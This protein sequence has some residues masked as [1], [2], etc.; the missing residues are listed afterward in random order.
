[1]SKLTLNNVADL[2][3][4]TTAVSV[5]NNNNDL[6]ETAVE[7]TLSLDG[8]VPN[9]MQSSF[10]MNSNQIINLPQ[11]A[12]GNSPLR[13]QDLEDFIGGGT[14]TN[15]PAGGNTN[16]VLTKASNSDYD[17]DWSSAASEVVAGANISVTG[18]S[19]AT[20][21]T[22]QNPNF[23]TSVTTPVINKVTITAPATNATLTIPDGV[24][25]TGPAVSGTAMTLGNT[26]VVTGAKTF[27]AATLTSPVINGASS[28][29]GVATASTPSTLVLR[30]AAGSA[31]VNSAIS[32]YTTTAT[33]AGTTTLT[34]SSTYNQ[35]FTGVT[36]QTVV[37]PVTSTLVLGQSYRIVNNSTGAVT[38]QSSG[39]NTVVIL[40]GNGCS[41]VVS[42]ILTSGT[43][44]ASWSASTDQ[45][46][47]ASGKTLTTNNSLTLAGTDGTT[48][49]FPTT[50]ATLARTDTSN[51]FTGVQTLSSQPILSSL[52][53][54]SAVATDGSKGLV[55]VTNT[56]SGNNVLATSPSLVTPVL[57][58][59]TATT[60][61]G[62][63]IDNNAWTSYTPAITSGGGTPTTVT[64]TGRYKQIGKTVIAQMDITITTVGTATGFLASTLPFAAASF[65]YGGAVFEYNA[66]N[67]SGAGFVPIGGTT[68]RCLDSTGTTFWVNG[69]GLVVQITY[70][71]P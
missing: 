71:V 45:E 34:V 65:R 46:L 28:G 52:T 4:A 31:Q 30:D 21:S 57:G 5:I 20:V 2:T 38:I 50:S 16:D 37:L 25:L 14:V 23:T 32:G 3:Q 42:C 53:A 18:A 58:A 13:L 62:V 63:T 22:I 39:A 24:T 15:I 8:T 6:I 49:T 35:Y 29:T 43:T 11:P 36:T 61:N 56:G 44:A 17:V 41:A 69:Y 47:T 64:A 9:S 55:S 40:P 48:M 12:T 7:N 60:I 10:D 19:P 26:E 54:S 59:A 27:G 67:K 70:E 1:M 51:T 33:A 66:T 68:I